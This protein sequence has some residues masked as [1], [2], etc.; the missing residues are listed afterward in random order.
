MESFNITSVCRDDI[1]HIFPDINT[2]LIQDDEMEELASKLA[3][4]YC[5]Q[6]FWNSLQV[7]IEECGLC[8]CIQETIKVL[9]PGKKG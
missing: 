8:P 7:L 2:D 5:D 4:D 9:Y 3:D 6:L 1:K